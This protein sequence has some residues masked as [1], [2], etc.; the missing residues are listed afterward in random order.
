[1]EILKKPI[2]KSILMLFQTN[3]K[4]IWCFQKNDS[5]IVAHIVPVH[6]FDTQFS[7]TRGAIMCYALNIF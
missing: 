7:F 1:M 2:Q 4:R 3:E 6:V 5:E